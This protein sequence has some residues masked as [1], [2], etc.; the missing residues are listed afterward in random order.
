MTDQAPSLRK[1][2]AAQSPII[3]PLIDDETIKLRNRLVRAKGTTTRTLI[4]ASTG[5]MTALSVVHTIEAKDDAHFVKVF[6]DGITAAFGLTKTAAKV[7]QAVLRVYEAERMKDGYADSVRLVWFD[8]QLTGI[9]VDM[10]QVTYRRGLKELLLKRF[11]A[12]RD[13]ASY[14]VNPALFFKGDRVA[15]IREY[16]RGK[17]LVI[18]EQQTLDLGD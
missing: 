17:N 12:P 18:A 16:R 6:S 2:N 10:S 14:W 5:E 1:L 9:D 13:G 15:F 3:N 8:D 4:D 11:L 7:F